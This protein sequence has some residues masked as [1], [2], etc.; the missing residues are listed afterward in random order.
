MTVKCPKCHFD[1]PEDT[2]FCGKCATPLPPTGGKTSE[3]LKKTISRIGQD[4]ATG[5][6]V[7]SKYRILDKLGAGG[8]GEVYRAEDISLN[9]QVA[10]KVLPDI[11][12]SD[13]ERLARFQREARVLA[14]LN[15][16]NIAAIY[17]VEEVD[18]KRFL[19][20][21]LVEGE[22]LAERL[23]KGPLSLEETLD[24]CRQVAEGLE[25]AHEKII[26]HR[27]L[28]PSN[29]KITP[30][31]KV[32]ILD[33]GLAR[34]FLDKSPV[35]FITD[36]P[37]ITAEMTQPGVILGTAAYMSPE[38][39]KGKQVDKRADIWA[40]G[41]ILFECLTGKAA[42]P[43][44]TITEVLA[45]V[46]KG[47]PDWD[48][49]PQDL[50]GNV[51]AVLRRCLQKDRNLRFH[52]IADARIEIDE[53]GPPQA[54][55]RAAIRR[56]PIGWV[57]VIGAALFIL[58]IL[59]R[60]W[61]WEAQRTAPPAGPIAAVVKLE[62]GYS[63]DGIRRAIDFN[64]P[65]RT[66]M[67][68]SSDGRFIVYC[69]V[70]D[71]A[72]AGA[73][74]RLFI[75]RIDELAARPIEG[76]E[77]GIAPFLSPDNRWVGFWADGKLKKI[78][79]DGGMAQTICEAATFFGASWGIND[80]I[81]F[82]DLAKH[83][84]LSTV[85]ASGG[86][87]AILTVP[88]KALEELNH[89]LPSFLPDA[90]G[91]LFTII[92]GEEDLNRR[93]ALFDAKTRKWKV[94]LDSAS[95]AR[96]VPTGHIVFLRWA[97]LMAV[98]FSLG[99]LGITGQAVAVR[100]NIM[101]ML[102]APALN[103]SAGQFSISASGSLIY[104]PGGII[105]DWKNSLVWVDRVGKDEPAKTKPGH[106]Y[107]PRIS[108]NGQKIAYQTLGTKREIWISDTI[109][110]I[111]FP[112]VSEALCCTPLWTPDG[113]KVIFGVRTS[114]Q[115]S[116]VFSRSADGSA[117]MEELIPSLSLEDWALSSLSPEGSRLALVGWQGKQAD[118]HL[119]DL[120]TKHIAPFR[121]AKYNEAYPAF[122][123][124]GSWLAYSSDQEGRYE[125]YVA[126]SSGATGAIKISNNG[127]TEPGWARS[128]KQLFYRSQEGTQ[129]WIVDVQTGGEFSA[130]KP[131]LLFQ[132]TGLGG[133][134]STRCWDISPDDQRFLMV[135]REERPLK[136]V[137]EIVIVQNWFE[138]LKRLVPS[139]KK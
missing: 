37:T 20:L 59:I 134:G 45:A 114:P 77:G 52:D 51:S 39:A 15:H 16:P 7:A 100:S 17:G 75:R 43:G 29:I 90:R 66:A 71:T 131:R 79:T 80:L 4:L 89:C 44:E 22:T 135:K 55:K 126:P 34:A 33:F 123:P 84:G 76:T 102:N 113:R 70:D 128:G 56:F 64:W 25:G 137:T 2:N 67:A 103:T 109:R 63:L 46:L 5:T 13:P 97:T 99:D 65:S 10:I 62:P 104:A 24:V 87:P 91:I 31:G 98:P 19:I 54:E 119:Y 26:I 3:E 130:G 122:S 23:S 117:P 132:R 32:K 35:E 12:A 83:P 58:G 81:V 120:T 74:P 38:Q 57:L 61:I 125:V 92:R 106:V 95:D 94:L 60:P 21:E 86:T 107:V 30:E 129:M 14:S 73:K 8:M 96:Y 124:D 41:C 40:F 11:F 110:D 53:A 121:A 111:S 101:Q 68:I 105:P 72:A 78:P 18:G 138:E 1:N 36:S 115:S 69:A 112:L 82:A 108:P 88:D 127:G 116:S 133:S 50:P 136:P 42:F 139:G 85:A 49:L 28:K 93:V 6:L 118:I 48:A 9:R 47:D 27:D